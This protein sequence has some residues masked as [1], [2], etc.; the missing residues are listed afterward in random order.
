MAS[1]STTLGFGGGGGGVTVTVVDA[2]REPPSPVTEIVYLVVT[3][4][5]TSLDPPAST[6]PIPWSIVAVAAAVEVQE[7]LAH[8]PCWT[9]AGSAAIDTLGAAGAGGGGG[10][11]V[12]ALLGHRAFARAVASFAL[13]IA[14]CVRHAQ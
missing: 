11:G 13:A 6:L 1:R 2:V 12:S 4:G 5:Q 7:S 8:L 3:V 14:S 10:G 9:S